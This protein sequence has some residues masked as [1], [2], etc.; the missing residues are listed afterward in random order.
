M[1]KKTKE[2][3]LEELRCGRRK[4]TQGKLRSYE[5]DSFC[6]LGV[7]CEVLE[8]DKDGFDGYYH[9]EGYPLNGEGAAD[10]FR[11]GESDEYISVGDLSEQDRSEL[12]EMNDKGV[13]FPEIADWIER[14]V[15]CED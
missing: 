15:I 8:Y 2:L 3:W 13:S 10:M 9:P 5:S 1:D 14:F 4:Q 11:Y 6:C 12:I 7:L